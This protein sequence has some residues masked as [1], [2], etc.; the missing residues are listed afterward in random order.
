MLARD[1]ERLTAL[2]NSVEDSRAYPCDVS[3]PDI[4]SATLDKISTQMAPPAVVIHNAVG[5]TRGSVLDITPQQL[6]RNFRI[7]STALLQI[8]QHCAPAMIEAGRGAILATGNTA[9]Y[10]GKEGFSGFAPT[11]AAQRILME[12][13][14]RELGPRGIHAAYVAI[15]AAIDL[16]WTRAALPDKPDDFFCKPADIASECFHL[17]H[18]PRSAWTF[19]VLIRPFGESW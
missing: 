8:I 6:E 1:E 14:A 18:Q 19:D 10:R 3:K 15:D 9:A 16:E 4:L 13:A 17:A 2:M 11:K 7:N 5:A 12:S